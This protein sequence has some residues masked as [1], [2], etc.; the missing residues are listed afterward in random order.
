MLKDDRDLR[1]RFAQRD[2]A[3]PRDILAVD[4]HAPRFWDEGTIGETK[5]RRLPCAAGTNQRDALARR[6]GEVDRFECDSLAVAVGDGFVDER[7]FVSS[8]G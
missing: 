3:Q 2:A 6:K 1:P 7:R 4:E 8:G 5:E